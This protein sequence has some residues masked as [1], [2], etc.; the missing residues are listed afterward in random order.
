MRKL[1]EKLFPSLLIRRANRYSLQLE[2]DTGFTLRARHGEDGWM[3]FL[4]DPYG[5]GDD[6]NSDWWPDLDQAIFDLSDCPIY[7]LYND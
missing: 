3:F 6:S 5:D 2:E 7:Y 1:L 4:I